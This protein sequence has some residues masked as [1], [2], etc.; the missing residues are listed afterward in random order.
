VKV[1]PGAASSEVT[2]WL[3]QTVKLRVAARPEK[4]KANAVVVALLAETL[5]VSADA[6]RVVTGHTSPRKLIE[7]DGLSAEELRRRL[8]G[9]G[10]N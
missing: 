8:G 5:G 2:G 3:G 9:P 4:G 1:V 6:V 10:S 7:V